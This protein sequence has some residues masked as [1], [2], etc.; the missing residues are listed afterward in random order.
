M[1]KATL[2]TTA[3]LILTACT[4]THI[5][6]THSDF[7]PI[8]QTTWTSVQGPMDL[9]GGK[10]QSLLCGTGVFQGCFP[11][12]DVSTLQSFMTGGLGGMAQGAGF[13]G[14]MGMLRGAFNNTN[15]NIAR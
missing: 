11:A 13:M 14:G 5:T 9:V 4:T 10:R 7:D 1:N 3:A 12:D 6:V 8:T 2:L 15:T